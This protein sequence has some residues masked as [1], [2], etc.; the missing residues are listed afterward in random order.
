MADSL[1]SNHCSIG[2]TSSRLLRR[3]KSSD[4]D[5]WRRLVGL[6]GR[7]VLYWCARAG[8]QRADRGDVVQ[9]VFRAVAKYLKHFRGD[10]PN[11]TFRGWLRR[12]TQNKITDYYRRLKRQPRAAGGSGA[13][14]MLLGIHE[15]EIGHE[16][17][18][19]NPTERS[20][21]VYQA[22]KRVREEFEDR[23]WQAFVRTT[24][25]G[26][27]STVAAE[28]LGMTPAAVRQAKSRVLRRLRDELQGLIG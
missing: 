5:A 12:V 11:D 24:A 7:L 14:E 20:L 4:Q 13:Y 23:T 1:G 15:L 16:D 2:S 3:A 22:M 6:Y 27:S 18:V 19:Q 17:D 21:L 8:L 9:E 26:L 25:D 10:R 28:A